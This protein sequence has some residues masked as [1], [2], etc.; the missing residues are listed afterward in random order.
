VLSGSRLRFEATLES[1]GD[2][3]ISPDTAGRIVFVNNVARSLLQ[4]MTSALEGKDLGDVVRIIDGQTRQG[5]ESPV[6]RAARE[7]LIVG[8]ARD[9]SLIGGALAL[10]AP[11]RAAIV[12][13]VAAWPGKPRIIVHDL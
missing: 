13:R 4:H 5:I 9:A 8:L 12:A 11:S 6:A 1:I 10:Q 2:G 3:L 7:R